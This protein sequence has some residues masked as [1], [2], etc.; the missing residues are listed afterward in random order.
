MHT[1]DCLLQPFAKP[2]ATLLVEPNLIVQASGINF[3]TDS[4]SAIDDLGY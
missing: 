4:R 1:L 3:E 2:R